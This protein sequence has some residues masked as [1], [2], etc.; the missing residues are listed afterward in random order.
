M[1]LAYPELVALVERGVIEGVQPDA[2]NAASIDVRLGNHFKYEACPTSNKAEIVDLAARESIRFQDIVCED[3]EFITLA[4]G[5]F[6]LA[7]T[8]EI[9][10]LPND[11]SAQF[12][13]KSSIARNG[14]D[15][16]AATW[17]DAG[18]HGSA[19]TL[20]LRNVTN[21][22]RLKLT[23]GMFLGQIKFYKHTEVDHEHSY[24]GRGRYNNDGA[25]AKSIKP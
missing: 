9:F 7:S 24:A 17:C 4:P 23:P 2:I 6:I 16:L 15:H 1:L 21:Y 13:L 19:L 3:G 18:W 5:Q 22:H 25:G 12:L 11:I 14:L 8:I 10:H 20:E